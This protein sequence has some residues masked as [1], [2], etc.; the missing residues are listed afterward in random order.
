MSQIEREGNIRFGDASLHITEEGLGKC[1]DFRERDKWELLFKRE[2]F[3]RII[4]TLNRTGWKCVIPQDVI[5]NYGRSFAEGR[6]YCVK[7]DLKADLEITGRCIELKMFQN[8]NAPDRS[9]HEGRYQNDKENHMP[10]LMRLE[11]ERTRRKIK[12][13]LCNIFTDYQFDSKF[14]CARGRKCAPGRL[15]SMEWLAE[16]Y[17]ESW[18]FKGDLSTYTIS[19]SNRTSA[20]KKFIQHGKRVWF[21]DRKGRI[22]TGIAYYNINSMWW[23]ITGK[24]DQT[25]IACFDLF[26]SPPEDVRQKRNGHLRERTLNTLMDE[27]VKSMAF[28]RAAKLRDLLHPELT[29]EA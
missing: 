3:R 7:G 10:Y 13:Y 17:N 28:E 22:C 19:D 1:K 29:G 4:Q 26:T 24:Y 11:M 6:R 14:G 25:N 21:A 27:A 20:D 23:V 18:H 15:T 2:V 8:I 12:N 16:V 5:D 9:D